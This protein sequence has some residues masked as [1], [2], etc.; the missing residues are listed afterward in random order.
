[1]I[2]KQ[3]S[4]TT[5]TF[6]SENSGEMKICWKWQAVRGAR[7]ITFGCTT[8]HICWAKCR[9]EVFAHSFSDGAEWG[10]L[11]VGWFGLGFFVHF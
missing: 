5:Y 4:D 8:S 1:M 2:E 9:R 3:I 11:M 6:T 7:K 10:A